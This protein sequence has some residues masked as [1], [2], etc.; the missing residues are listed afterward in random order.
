MYV[1]IRVVT[2]NIFVDYKQTVKKLI[3]NK[4]RM[5]AIHVAMPLQHGPHGLTGSQVAWLCTIHM[6]EVPLSED[7]LRGAP[8]LA[9]WNGGGLTEMI[10]CLRPFF[11]DDS[12]SGVMSD[13]VNKGSSEVE[14]FKL[15]FKV[16]FVFSLVQ[17]CNIHNTFNLGGKWMLPH[18]RYLQWVDV[19]FNEFYT[20]I[21]MALMMG[22]VEKEKIRD[23]WSTDVM[24]QT[25]LF[26]KLLT[27]YCLCSIMHSLKFSDNLLWNTMAE[28][29]FTKYD[30]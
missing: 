18:S 26:S 6:P 4:V 27:S 11:F 30:L 24:I 1:S 20:F 21:A 25:P 19:T 14:F 13:K 15:L 5:I 12:C 3:I 9:A 23:Y 10:S 28:N 16:K 8:I 7:L 2:C 29:E 22:I 17:L